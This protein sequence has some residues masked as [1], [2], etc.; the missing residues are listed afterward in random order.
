MVWL[1]ELS[2]FILV[3]ATFL[4]LEASLTKFTTSFS[5]LTD[6]YL[7]PSMYTPAFLDSLSLS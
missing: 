5:H 2:S 3:E 6:I 1:L 4:F 7:N